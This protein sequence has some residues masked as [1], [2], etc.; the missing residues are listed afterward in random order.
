MDN[1]T[2]PQGVL[3]ALPESIRSYIRHLETIIKQQQVQIHDLKAQLSQ[4]QIL[5][6]QQRAQVDGLQTRVREL[7][8]R[9]S[10]DSSNS[11]KP[12]SSDPFKK[13]PRSLRGKSGKKAGGQPGHKGKGLEQ[14]ATPD[15][16]VTHSPQSCENCGAGLEG[17][18]GRCA[19]RRQLFDLLKPKVEVTEHQVEEKRCPCCGGLNRASFPSHIRGYVQYGERIQGLAAYFAHQHF[20][21][22]DRLCQLFE[23]VFGVAI[24][25]GTCSNIDERLFEQLD[26]FERDL[27]ESL[28]ESS[29]LHFDETGSQCEKK[30]HWVHVASS[31]LGTL[32]TIDQKRGH[33]GMEAAGIL[34]LFKGVGVHDH[35]SSYFSY[36]KIAHALCNAHHLRELTFIHEE[37]GETWAKEMKELLILAKKEVER[38]LEES[39]LE[40]SV[41]MGIEQEYHQIIEKGLKYHQELPDLP[42]G[43]RGKQKQRAGKNL[44]DRLKKDR[45]SV[46]RFIYDF[47]VPFTNNRAEQ[48]IRMIKVKQ[49]VSGCFRTLLGGKIFCRVRS[50]ISTARKQGWS[51][52]DALAD[53]I[54]GR[55]RLLRGEH[56]QASSFLAAVV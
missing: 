30:L 46:L 52:W 44:L 8:A 19:E 10:K 27:K 54:S 38:R 11:S 42:R 7:E 21:P 22:S 47:S 18:D 35:W 3:D 15:Q 45:E 2:L 20:I 9:L 32:Y 40:Q 56:S 50:Y 23:D 24:S 31:A 33:E 53:A 1:I 48:D 51:I 4:Q 17:V 13:K 49:K 5:I 41:Q 16:I 37:E 29:V 28:L 39:R 25:P 14:V 43:K 12:P 34:P 6:D 55:P 36:K 26:P